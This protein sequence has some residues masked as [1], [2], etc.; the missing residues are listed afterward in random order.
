MSVLGAKDL[1]VAVFNK[2]GTSVHLKDDEMLAKAFN[3]ASVDFPEFFREF[4]WHPQYKDSRLLSRTLQ[5]L[6]LGGDIYRENASGMDLRISE[7]VADEYG[8]A[9]FSGLPSEAQTAVSQIA[10][11]IREAYA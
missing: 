10:E 7:R 6:D 2:V 11:K 4:A 3:D 1:V 5:N 9:V 8:N